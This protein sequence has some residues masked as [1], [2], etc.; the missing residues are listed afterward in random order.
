LTSLLVERL[1]QVEQDPSLK[2]KDRWTQ[3]TV[4]YRLR[5]IMIKNHITVT[6]RHITSRIKNICEEKLGK[7]R[8]ELGIIAADRAQ[9]FF[10]GRWHDVGLDELPSLVKMGTCQH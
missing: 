9:L 4:F 7:K 1:R 6:R 8:E 3:S 10:R 5:P 2:Q